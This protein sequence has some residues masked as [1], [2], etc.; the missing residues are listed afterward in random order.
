MI[1]LSS[2]MADADISADVSDVASVMSNDG[3]DAADEREAEDATT[4][5]GERGDA[6]ARAGED[7]QTTS[8]RPQI[9]RSFWG[10]TIGSFAS[11]SEAPKE[12]KL[13]SPL[14]GSPVE[15]TLKITSTPI[16]TVTSSHGS[17]TSRNRVASLFA[18]SGTTERNASRERKDKT[19]TRS[20]TIVAPPAPPEQPIN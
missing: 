18:G 13:A 7:I 6:L 2:S 1:S 14:L 16:A 12:K 4:P 20:G 19:R 9:K 8:P 3:L 17:T 11:T 15:D 10:S 5:R